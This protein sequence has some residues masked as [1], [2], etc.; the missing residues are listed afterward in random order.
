MNLHS[1]GH[2]PVAK[3]AALCAALLLCGCATLGRGTNAAWVVTEDTSMRDY[4]VRLKLSFDPPEAAFRL[5][6]QIE[7]VTHC[8]WVYEGRSTV[9]ELRF[10]D[11]APREFGETG[12][13]VIFRPD[14]VKITLSNF[15]NSGYI[16]ARAEPAVI[17][18]SGVVRLKYVGMFGGGRK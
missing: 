10:N 18:R 12:N 5:G 8:C 9:A 1:A 14:I 11:T 7:C 6:R 15:L 2:V 4:C 3:T 13:T 17:D 16:R